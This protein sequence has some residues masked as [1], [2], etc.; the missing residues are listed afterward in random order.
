MH[1]EV[2]KGLKVVLAEPKLTIRKEFL[3]ELQALGCT[4]V[5]Q[6]GNLADVYKAFEAG[7]VDVLIGDTTMPE[8]DLSA[9][10]RDIRHGKL[11]DNPF[12]IAMA[13]ISKGDTGKLEGV[14]NSGVDDIQMKPITTGDLRKRILG[15][16]NG[17][18]KFV[19][20]TD[21]VGPDRRPKGA[22]VP[23]T[24]EV[25]LIK[26]PNPLQMRFSGRMGD[27]ASARAIANAVVV[28]NEQ[29][30]ERHAYSVN[31]LMEKISKMQSGELPADAVDMTAQLDRL[32]KIAGDI[33]ARLHGT[34][35]EHAKEMCMTLEQMSDVLKKSPELAGKDEV[36]L[37]Q[38]LTQVI[39]RKC[40][41]EFIDEYYS[42]EQLDS[43]V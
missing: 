41:G 24:I 15:L 39:R 4:D 21:Y 2:L 20:T 5:I 40:N 36:Y 3:E 12:I 26:V 38:R 33:S 32:H 30:V 25:P 10:I 29:K 7:G 35:Y 14:I 23:G 43:A 28:V 22:V 18:K 13:L 9:A 16:A 11:G 1:A 37:L 42:G 34:T 31:W 19:V 8:G 6:T 27:T 17:R